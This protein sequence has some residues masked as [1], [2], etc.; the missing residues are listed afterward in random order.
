MD[1]TTFRDP[2]TVKIFNEK[3]I[4]YKVNAES[5]AGRPIAA[6]YHIDAYPTFLFIS[7]KGLIV[8]R[9]EG[10]YPP[11]LM[12]EQIIFAENYRAENEH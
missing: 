10:V 2:S 11:N 9:L 3:F 6:L 5:E 1:L 12:Q 4:C 8:N 7:P